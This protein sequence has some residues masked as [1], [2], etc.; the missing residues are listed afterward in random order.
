MFVDFKADKM[1]DSV[2][3]S[4]SYTIKRD[5]SAGELKAKH[6]AVILLGF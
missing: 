3:T 6:Q 5:S 1:T 4:T 2:D